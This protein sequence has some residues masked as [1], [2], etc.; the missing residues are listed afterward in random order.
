MITTT[1]ENLKTSINLI[2]NETDRKDVEHSFCEFAEDIELCN[3]LKYDEVS[4]KY[5]LYRNYGIDS[6]SDP[7]NEVLDD[8]FG[9]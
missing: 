3:L 4:A 7:I 6:E 5:R 2:E 9:V 1:F 8:F